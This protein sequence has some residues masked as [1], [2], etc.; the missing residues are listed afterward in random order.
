M[1]NSLDFARPC[2]LRLGLRSI[3][4]PC[5]DQGNL[6]DWGRQKSTTRVTITTRVT[7]RGLTVGLR[8]HAQNAV[9]HI[10]SIIVVCNH[11]LTAPGWWPVF[12]GDGNFIAFGHGPDGAGK[13]ATPQIGSKPGAISTCNHDLVNLATSPVNIKI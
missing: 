12:K 10:P 5:G 2:N 6:I 4:I 9:R 7:P 8:T 13:T 3:T 11:A 1:M